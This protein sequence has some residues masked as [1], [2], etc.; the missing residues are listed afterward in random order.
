M[1]DHQ[2]STP[3][4]RPV[5]RFEWEA[6]FRAADVAPASVKLIGFVLSTYADSRTGTS[7]RPGVARLAADLH[8]SERTISRGLVAL[9]AAGWVKCI[10]RGSSYGRGGRGMSS[11]YRLTVPTAAPEQ[12]TPVSPDIAEKQ[13]T[14]VS[15]DVDNPTPQGAEHP[16]AVTRTTDSPDGTADSPDGTADTGVTPPPHGIPPHH[17]SP[18]DPLPGWTVTSPG[19]VDN[20]AEMNDDDPPSQTEDER[21]RAEWDRL[22]AWAEANGYPLEDTA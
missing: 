21:A 13:P 4:T 9:E 3:A 1:T 11:E 18:H 8:T 6:Q 16:T 22:Q 2:T 7:I 10:R 20:S 17:S 5:G 14:P 19:P 12:P 15:P